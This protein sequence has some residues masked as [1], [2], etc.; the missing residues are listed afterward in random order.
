MF[1]RTLEVLRSFGTVEFC[2][3]EAPCLEFKSMCH[4]QSRFWLSRA[5]W[6]DKLKCLSPQ[7]PD[8]ACI[9]IQH[10]HF[11]LYC[12]CLSVHSANRNAGLRLFFILSKHGYVSLL[13]VSRCLILPISK[14][15][16]LPSWKTSSES[17]TSQNGFGLKLPR[18]LFVFCTAL[19]LLWLLEKWQSILFQ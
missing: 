6:W 7:C 8:N 9:N 19:C 12:R 13:P 17:W 3:I 4:L 11:T 15:T 5:F 14:L 2:T 1:R 10:F 18:K 16:L